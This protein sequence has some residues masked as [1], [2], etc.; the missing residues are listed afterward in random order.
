MRA[1]KAHTNLILND[2]G[3]NKRNTEKKTD[4]AIEKG[5]GNP[6]QD[7]KVNYLLRISP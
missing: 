4:L 6:G 5:P 7:S 1:Y 2:S 3:L